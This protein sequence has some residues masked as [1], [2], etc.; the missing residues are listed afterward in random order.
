MPPVEAGSD[1]VPAGA[2]RRGARL[3]RVA[4]LLPVLTA[5]VLGLA[6]Y[7]ALASIDLASIHPFA[8]SLGWL[9]VFGVAAAV[10]VAA[11]L[12]AVTA[13]VRCRPRAV[14]VLALAAALA[15]PLPVIGVAVAWGG[16]SLRDNAV[17]DL[18]TD[19][20][21][22]MRTLGVLEAWDVPVNP[23]RRLLVDLTPTGAP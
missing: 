7:S 13:C 15:L 10:S 4:L 1:T 17:A 6:A 21:M 3:A 2:A 5:G 14:G 18:R 9:T 19:S 12:V 20:A 8:V 22:V 11:V 16:Q 23:V